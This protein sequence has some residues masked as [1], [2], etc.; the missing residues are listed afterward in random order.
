M[1]LIGTLGLIFGSSL[2]QFGRSFLCAAHIEGFYDII[3]T[4]KSIAT[5]AYNLEGFITCGYVYV[6][7]LGML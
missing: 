3:F 6:N 7:G 5:D 4:M 2:G 1:F